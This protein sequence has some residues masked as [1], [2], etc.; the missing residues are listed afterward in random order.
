MRR[1]LLILLMTLLPLQASWAA[2]CA[3]C[4]G[5]CSFETD[6]G[7]ASVSQQDD[8]RGAVMGD[9]DCSCCQVG[10]VAIAPAVPVSHLFTAPPAFAGDAGIFAPGSLRPSRPERPKWMR[11]ALSGALSSPF[12]P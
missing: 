11:A 9:D 2:V 3:Y 8:E 1:L 5:P 6:A 12:I 7:T 10:S 4:P